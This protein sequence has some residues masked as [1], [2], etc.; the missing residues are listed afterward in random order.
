M[1]SFV[2]QFGKDG[3]RVS[4]LF[5]ILCKQHV[6]QNFRYLSFTCSPNPS[7]KTASSKERQIRTTVR[8]GWRESS[9]F[10]KLPFQ[11][12]LGAFWENTTAAHLSFA[13]SVYVVFCMQ[14]CLHCLCPE[15]GAA[16]QSRLKATLLWLAW[17]PSIW[18][19]VPQEHTS[20]SKNC[21]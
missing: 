8:T 19:G 18:L 9:F 16:N 21:S 10:K 13:F 6:Y 15:L 4:F 20:V 7:L 5:L 14:L 3:E 12:S 17:F 1:G 2:F 11:G